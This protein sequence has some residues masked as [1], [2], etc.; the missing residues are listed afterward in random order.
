MRCTFL[1]VQGFIHTL[2]YNFVTGKF[3]VRGKSRVVNAGKGVT[4][5]EYKSWFNNQKGVRTPQLIAACQ[6]STIKLCGYVA[7]HF[8]FSKEGFSSAFIC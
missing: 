6:D 5:L 7:T 1:P 4:S 2:E 8:P 3:L